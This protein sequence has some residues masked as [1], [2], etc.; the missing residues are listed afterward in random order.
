MLQ[1]QYSAVLWSGTEAETKKKKR[2]FLNFFLFFL[3]LK[4]WSNLWDNFLFVI[5]DSLLLV[6]SM[7][8]VNRQLPSYSEMNTGSRRKGK[9]KK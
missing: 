5:Q 4:L 1:R 8:K 2:N 7:A 9:Q 3:F 6:K